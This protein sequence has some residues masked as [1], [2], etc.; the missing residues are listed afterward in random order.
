MRVSVLV[1]L[2]LACA[3]GGGPQPVTIASPNGAPVRSEPGFAASGHIEA[4]LA[5]LRALDAKSADSRADRYAREVELMADL[6]RCTDARALAREIATKGGEAA[7]RSARDAVAECDRLERKPTPAELAPMREVFHQARRVEASD[8]RRA[9]KLYAEAWADAPSVAAMLGLARAAKASGDAALAERSFERALAFVEKDG[10][11]A[12]LAVSPGAAPGETALLPLD[13]RNGTATL[14]G[15]GFFFRQDLATGALRVLA[16]MPSG[17]DAVAATDRFALLVPIITSVTVPPRLFEIGVD[18][19]L[20]ATPLDALVGADALALSRDGVIAAASGGGAVSIVE[21]ATGKLLAKT[22]VPGESRWIGV[23]TDRDVVVRE[24]SL[25]CVLSAPSYSA[26]RVDAALNAAS[27]PYGAPP[28]VAGRRVAFLDGFNAARVYDVHDA[29]VVRNIPGKFMR[30]SSLSLSPD[31]GTL[32][33]TSGTRGH[34]FWDLATGSHVTLGQIGG[35]DD[36]MAPTW[37]DDSKRVIVERAILGKRA[38]RVYALASHAFVAAGA[39]PDDHASFALGPRGTLWVAGF[40]VVSRVDLARRTIRTFSVDDGK[41]VDVVV[42]PD[43]SL[44]A[45]RLEAMGVEVFDANGKRLATAEIYAGAMRFEGRDLVVAG[46]G[47]T[48]QVLDVDTQ[49]V[50]TRTASAPP[51]A[52]AAKWIARNGKDG[53]IEIEDTSNH[54]VSTIDLAGDALVVTGPDGKGAI[55][56]DEASAGCRVGSAWLP[57]DACRDRLVGRSPL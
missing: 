12:A 36:R 57:L 15:A 1:G 27:S 40:G 38:S 33:S 3:C 56:G 30:V 31:G 45:V 35:F 20:T 32:V 34:Y 41:C 53:L 44:V 39:L 6:L 8:P 4:E 47:S 11:K 10:D 18:D 29:R 49:K 25:M 28:V 5:S 22:A 37:A 13:V 54:A 51:A 9:A 14:T 43:E 26:C 48:E 55:G 50:T 17:Y 42:S 16:S 46:A 23:T 2:A 24:A 7:K 21:L 19:E 52:P